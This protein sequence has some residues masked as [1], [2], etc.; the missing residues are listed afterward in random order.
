MK[1]R[2]HQAGFTLLE[3]VLAVLIFGM[4]AVALVEAINSMGQT[5]IK[6]RRYAAVVSRME[7]LLT[8]FTRMP[9]QPNTGDRSVEQTVK[10][11][12]VEYRLRMEPA[13]LENKD[14]QELNELYSVKATATWKEGSQTEEMSTETLLYPPL[15]A[16]R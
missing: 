11:D 3:A 12:G 2:A 4:A 15:Y 13:K 14:R 9:Q 8:E 5:A 6:A 7:S 10:E 16:P 1:L